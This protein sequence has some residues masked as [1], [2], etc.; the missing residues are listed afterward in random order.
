MTT[1]DKRDTDAATAGGHGRETFD[2]LNPATGEVV[3]TFDVMT[4]AQVQ[5]VVDAARPAARWWAE[6]GPDG[7]KQRLLAWRTSLA[8]HL[9]ELAELMHTENGK[10]TDDALFEIAV[11]IEHLDWAARHAGRIL[12]RHRT[13]P[14]VLAANHST[15][16][17]YQPYGVVGVIGPWNYPV[18]TPMG[19]ISYA[20]AAGN[21]VVFKP[22][23]YTTAVGQWLVRSLST[24]VP[25]YPVFSLATG[26]ADT[27]TA[28]CRSGVDKLAFT[29]STGTGKK[30]MATCAETLTPVVIE[31]GG[32]D[33]L[34][35]LDDADVDAAADAAVW[36]AMSNAGQTC[37]GIER[38]YVTP[39]AYDRFVSEVTRRASG[40]R[41][42]DDRLAD[43]GPITMPGQVDVIR[44]H[45][46]EALDRGATA[47]VGGIES[48]RAPFVDPIVLTDVPADAAAEQD[49]T[50]GPTLTVNKVADE[51]EAV[52]RAN[53]T[54]YGLGAAVYSAGRGRAVADRLRAG[55]VS[56]NSVITFAAV[57]S[58]PFGGIGASGFGRIHGPDGLR[59]FAWSR[60]VTRRR[61]AGPINLQTFERKPKAF[62]NLV[63][64]VQTVWG[65]GV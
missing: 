22:S 53:A 27:G 33:A 40:L 20:L 25:E 8:K 54:A 58:V 30:V 61:F 28:L 29:G 41:A 13:L 18:H 37:V 15:S 62:Q 21:A 64:L 10:P 1:L 38:A 55:M 51:D 32:K 2:S 35:V 26:L 5:A 6:L 31:C 39:G 17:S 45:V 12:G 59:E 3:A 44:R 46:Q 65:R 11:A 43:M 42:G 34:V 47:V 36:G 60:A 7:R 49:E 56:I 24:V 50:F 48:V 4:A 19:S 9:R 57:P 16:V 14:G 52:R 23:E 63:T